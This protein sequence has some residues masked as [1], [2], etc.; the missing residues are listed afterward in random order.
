[1]TGPANSTYCSS[2]RIPTPSSSSYQNR[3]ISTT[4]HSLILISPRIHHSPSRNVPMRLV[5]HSPLAFTTPMGNPK[6]TKYPSSLVFLTNQNFGHC[7]RQDIDRKDS[8]RCCPSPYGQLFILDYYCR[9]WWGGIQLIHGSS[10]CYLICSAQ[11]SPRL[12]NVR[13]SASKMV[14]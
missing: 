14:F 3:S 12:C 1:M 2:I 4:Y 7:F 6:S 9:Q 5:P 13:L 11:P 8:N 10:C